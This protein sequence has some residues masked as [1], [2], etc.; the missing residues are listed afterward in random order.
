MYFG[1]YMF[2]DLSMFENEKD[3]IDWKVIERPSVFLNIFCK[4]DG[5]EQ[6]IDRIVGLLWTDIVRME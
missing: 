4:P 1:F 2:L 3:V 6:K 5:C